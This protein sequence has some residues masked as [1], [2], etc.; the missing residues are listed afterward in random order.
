MKIL[1]HFVVKTGKTSDEAIILAL[2]ELNAKEED[3]HIEIIEK[4]SKGILG[5]IGGKEAKVKVALKDNKGEEAGRCLSQIL[6]KMNI[7]YEIE[8]KEESDSIFLEIKGSDVGAVIGRRGET[9]NAIQYLVSLMINKKGKNFKRVFIDAGNYKQKR[10]ETLIDLAKRMANKVVKNKK[11]IVLEPMNPYERRII[12]AYLQS[13]NNVE[14]SSEGQEP[15]R[16]VV[17]KPKE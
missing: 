13:D 7:N 14:T 5:I 8:I 17:I 15:Y 4:G 11:G 1:N 9:L 10:K 12:H 16:K 6:D 2:K 3:V